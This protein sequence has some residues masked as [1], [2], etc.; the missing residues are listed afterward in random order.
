M[1]MDRRERRLSNR[2]GTPPEYTNGKFRDDKN[3]Y[4]GGFFLDPSSPNILRI[5][6]PT[7]SSPPPRS[8]SPDRG[9]IEHRVSKFDTLAG[10]AIKY[11]VEVG[12]VKKMNGLVTDLQMFALK[13][14]RIPLPG[15]HPPSPCLSIGSSHHGEGCSCHELEPQNDTNSDAFDSFQSLRL[16]SSKKKGYYGLKPPIRTVSVGGSLEMGTYKKESNGDSQY[17]RPFPSTNTPLNHH[18]KSRSLVNALLEE[19]NQSSQEPSSNKFMRRRQKSEADFT[20]RTPELM[21][22][23]ENTSSSNG[24]FLSSVGGKGLAL[25]SKASSRTSLSSAE[26]ET[27]SFNPVPMNLM[28]APVSDSFASVR[29]SSSASSLQ[30]PDGNSNNGSSSLSLWS[31][32]TPAAITSSIFDGLPKPLT[33]RRNKTA[34]D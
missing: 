5:P 32:S 8:S 17:L 4:G 33:G 29:K 20:S 22:K 16:K 1:F 9:Y 27:C 34:M 26:S 7:S 18:R 11:G 10:V 25:R 14:L 30:D 12:D 6:S 28:D 15:R 19:F 21:L 13:S 24:G 23:E 31:T 2:N 3:G